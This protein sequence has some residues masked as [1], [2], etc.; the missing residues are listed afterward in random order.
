MFI[1]GFFFPPFTYV[2]LCFQ[3]LHSLLVSAFPALMCYTCIYLSPLCV[4][5]PPPPCV[6]CQ[7]FII[8]PCLIIQRFSVCSW[9]CCQLPDYRPFAWALSRLVP[10]QRPLPN[11]RRRLLPE[12]IVACESKSIAWVLTS[13]LPAESVPLPFRSLKIYKMYF[14]ELSPTLE[15]AV[16]TPWLSHNL[17]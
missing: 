16:C 6:L 17:R 8:P 14:T 15:S 1:S 4:Y 5:T 9:S 10:F 13:L 7:F 3:C 2:C 12:S 11:S